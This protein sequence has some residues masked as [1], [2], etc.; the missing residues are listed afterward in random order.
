MKTSYK[1]NRLV[2]NNLWYVSIAN[3][4]LQNEKLKKLKRHIINYCKKY[5]RTVLPLVKENNR[6]ELFD[7]HESVPMDGQENTEIVILKENLPKDESSLIFE[8]FPKEEKNMKNYEDTIYPYLEGNINDTVLHSNTK[9]YCITNC[10]KCDYISHNFHFNK[11]ISYLI[12]RAPLHLESYPG[13]DWPGS[14]SS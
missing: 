6:D 9:N 5:S 3:R 14:I 4:I 1:L 8:D 11:F 13:K 12:H 10:D 2:I 7:I